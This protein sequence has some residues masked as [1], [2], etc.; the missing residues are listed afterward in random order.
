MLTLVR[1]W[2]EEAHMAA[3]AEPDRKETVGL[4]GVRSMG[5][6]MLTMLFE[7]CHGLAAFDP[8]PKADNI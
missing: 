6:C 4:I 1:N 2:P 8:P 7:A 3:S 5:R